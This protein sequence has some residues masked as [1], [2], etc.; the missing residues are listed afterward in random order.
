M[1]SACI[2]S[3]RFSSSK[4]Q[5]SV[6]CILRCLLPFQAPGLNQHTTDAADPT[7]ASKVTQAENSSGLR[8]G[9]QELRIADAVILKNLN[10]ADYEI[11]I[12]ALEVGAYHV[13][14]YRLCLPSQAH[15]IKA[16]IHQHLRLH[17]PKRLL[18][19]HY[20]RCC[21]PSTEQ[22]PGILPHFYASSITK[23]IQNDH[24]FMSHYHDPGDGFANL[25][26][27]SEWIED[28][29]SSSS[30]VVRK[31]VVQKPKRSM[32]RTFSE[33]VSQSQG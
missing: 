6:R 24:I 32:E 1:K 10:L 33:A 15:S 20:T 21:R 11:Q 27:A 26:A 4:Y 13:T 18:C 3:L 16:Y 28:D 31:S 12:Q 14:L 23:T 7:A 9:S 25:E 5:R 22:A 17:S 2:I 19:C 8:P 30:S 29:R